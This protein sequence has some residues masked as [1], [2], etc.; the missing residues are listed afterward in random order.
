MRASNDSRLA[1]LAV[2]VS[3]ELRL[4]EPAEFRDGVNYRGAALMADEF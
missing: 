4:V 1:V 3:P 2:N